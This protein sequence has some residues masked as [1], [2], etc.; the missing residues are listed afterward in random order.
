[1]VGHDYTALRDKHGRR[2]QSPSQRPYSP[3]R[4]HLIS[5]REPGTASGF[6]MYRVKRCM[7]PI[8]FHSTSCGVT[9]FLHDVPV[10]VRTPLRG[11]S[12]HPFS[13]GDLTGTAGRPGQGSGL[14]LCARA[15]LKSTSPPRERPEGVGLPW[16]VQGP[17]AGLV[18]L[19]QSV[20]G[21]PLGHLRLQISRTIAH[22]V[23]AHP[24]AW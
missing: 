9:R 6:C 16:A 13:S 11:A 3:E 7:P 12:S 5:S 8:S 4:P 17:G 2:A 15:V 22:I 21:S 23:L 14:H 20:P 24:P 19:S 1:M 18:P 10:G